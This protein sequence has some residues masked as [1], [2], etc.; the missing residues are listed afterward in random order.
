[1]KSMVGKVDSGITVLFNAI[2]HASVG[3][4]GRWGRQ[5]HRLSA[6]VSIARI[7]STRVLNDMQLHAV[8]L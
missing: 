7:N 8:P 5:F 3:H 4:Y 2:T 6:A 1:V